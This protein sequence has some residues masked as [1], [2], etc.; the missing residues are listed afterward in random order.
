LPTIGPAI[1]VGESSG[2]RLGEIW[3]RSK[4]LGL[5]GEFLGYLRTNSGG[6]QVLSVSEQIVEPD[7]QSLGASGAPHGPAIPSLKNP[8]TGE[9]GLQRRCGCPVGLN[10]V[11]AE[12]VCTALR[13]RAV[14][15]QGCE[16]QIHCDQGVTHAGW[17][18]R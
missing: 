1:Q 13:H 6:L 7:L 12:V 9:G 8:G 18:T 16:H 5:L 2:S 15:N 4:H 11:V 17:W 14:V 10:R 3:S